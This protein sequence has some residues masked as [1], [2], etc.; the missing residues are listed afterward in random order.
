MNNTDLIP[1]EKCEFDISLN[2]ASNLSG[3]SCQLLKDSLQQSLN[4][5]HLMVGLLS[6]RISILLPY[7]VHL[8]NSTQKLEVILLNNRLICLFENVKC[9]NFITP[10]HFS[11]NLARDG[12][13]IL[14]LMECFLSFPDTTKFSM[15]VGFYV[16]RNFTIVRSLEAV[17][18]WNLRHGLRGCGYL[19]IQLK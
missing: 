17:T 9:A 2:I 12:I 8:S 5:R 4:F 16:S 3:C 1:L 15:T 7:M 6:L 11:K 10:A 19:F 14:E 13:N 18:F